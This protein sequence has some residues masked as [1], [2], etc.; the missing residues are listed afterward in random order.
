VPKSLGTR[1][2][3][4]EHYQHHR[5][6]RQVAT[7]GRRHRRPPQLLEK[8]DDSEISPYQLEPGVRRE[9]FV[10]ELYVKIP[11]DPGLKT[12]LSYPHWEFP[13]VRGLVASQPRDKHGQKGSFQYFRRSNS[14]DG[15][16]DR[17]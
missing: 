16:S 9:F 17:G 13:F 3:Y 8:A 10:A 6:E 4:P 12:A 15:M 1:Q 11:L 14:R 7:D 5:P 2:E